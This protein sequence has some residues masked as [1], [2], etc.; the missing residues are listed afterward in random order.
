MKHLLSL[1]LVMVMG[2]VGCGDPL[3]TLEEN[4]NTIQRNQ[5]GD[6]VCIEG[7]YSEIT[8]AGLAKLEGFTKLEILNLPGRNGVDGKN[9]LT[10]GLLP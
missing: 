10:V 3:A 8:D 6:V 2:M 4:G 1:L 7:P 5:H 9:R